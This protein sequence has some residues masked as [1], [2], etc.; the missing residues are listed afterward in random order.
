MQPY[1]EID[2]FEFTDYL[3]E[4]E[5][6]R[7]EAGN[8]PSEIFDVFERCWRQDPLERPTLKEL[9]NST[10]QFYNSLKNYV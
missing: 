8:C 6:N 10:H 4:R 5:S 9:F 1:A 3:A 7:L 2:P